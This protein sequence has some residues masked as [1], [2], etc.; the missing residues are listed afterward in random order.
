MVIFSKDKCGKADKGFSRETMKNNNNN[1]KTKTN[2][3]PADPNQKKCHR[4]DKH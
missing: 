2:S 4:E 3:Q 1:N